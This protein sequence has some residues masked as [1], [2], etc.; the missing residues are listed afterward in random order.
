MKKKFDFRR[1]LSLKFKVKKIYN[2]KYESIERRQPEV[3]LNNQTKRIFPD[4]F[5]Q[6]SYYSENNNKLF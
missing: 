4:K 3:S 5:I 6:K 2:P 1:E